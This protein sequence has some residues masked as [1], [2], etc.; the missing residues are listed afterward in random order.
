RQE[1][2]RRPNRVGVQS[3]GEGPPR[4][5]AAIEEAPIR[6]FRNVLEAYRQS[7]TLLAAHEL[8]LFPII[9]QKPQTAEDVARRCGASPRGME[10]LLNA[11]VGLGLLHK[12]GASY[13]LPRELAPYL[14]PG[15]EGDATGMLDAAGELYGSWRDL[16]RG[17]R[18]VVPLH[19]LS[20]DALLN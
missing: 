2:G 14:V 18:E 16:A 5:A 11:L 4:P 8:G 9:H 17:V 10:R 20:S 13:V 6:R 19:R 12:H 3:A 15:V 1:R 7:A